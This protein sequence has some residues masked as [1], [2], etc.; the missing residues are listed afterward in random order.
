MIFVDTSVWI[1]FLRNGTRP[2]VDELRLLIDAD[3]VALASIVRLEILG[4]TSSKMLPTLRRTLAAVPTFYPSSGTWSLLETW[5][6]RTVRAGQC[7]GAADLLIAALANEQR[8]SV[9]SLDADFE[10][11]AKLGLVRVHRTSS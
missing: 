3:E 6:D 7:F 1:A 9:W 10:R 5:I 4:G 11:M 8:S 2:V